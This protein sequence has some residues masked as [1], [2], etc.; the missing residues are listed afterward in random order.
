MSPADII[1]IVLVIVAVF[2]ALRAMVKAKKKG[3]CV[4]CSGCSDGG[5]CSHCEPVKRD[6]K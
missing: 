6:K 1:V 3:S 5:C 2:F 4:G